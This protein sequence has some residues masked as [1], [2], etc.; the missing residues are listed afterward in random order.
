MLD[1]FLKELDWLIIALSVFK[2]IFFSGREAGDREDNTHFRKLHDESSSAVAEEREC[3]ACGGDG[4]RN[5]RD[6]EDRLNAY[7]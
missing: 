3:N 5:D 2:R 4:C 1:S 6:I 7:L